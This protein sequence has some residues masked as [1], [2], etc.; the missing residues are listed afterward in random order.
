MFC[1]LGGNLK[2]PTGYISKEFNNT[3]SVV[4]LRVMRESGIALLR[5]LFVKRLRNVLTINEN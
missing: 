2:L 3:I 1:A 4:H 5:Q